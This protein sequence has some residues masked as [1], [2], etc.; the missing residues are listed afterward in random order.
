M[1]RY[2]GVAHGGAAKHSTSHASV[3][4]VEMAITEGLDR[5][6]VPQIGTRLDEVL[7]LRPTQLVIDLKDCPFVDAAAIGLL[8]DAHRRLWLMDGLLSLRAP[9]PRL[10]R[11]LQAARVDHVL[12]ILPDTEPPAAPSTP[13]HNAA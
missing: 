13:P 4:L 1:T 3:R 7:A 5:S 11:I 8:L 2:V 12:H 6:T 10:R 9:T